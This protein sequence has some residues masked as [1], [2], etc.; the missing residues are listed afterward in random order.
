MTARS[1]RTT[2]RDGAGASS[3]AV[4]NTS[5]RGRRSKAL[6]N[7]TDVYATVADIAGVDLDEVIP[8][9]LF[10]DSVSVR[11]LL[12]DPDNAS[13]RKYAFADYFKPNGP[14]P[15]D[16]RRRAIRDDRWKLI[17]RQPRPPFRYEFYDLD[18]APPGLD[19]DDLCPCPENLDRD[20]RAA[21]ERL[22]RELEALGGP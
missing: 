1:Y 19:G 11:P 22:L 20:E 3:S 9:E 8:H 16:R 14:G 21:Y 6:V 12:E 10:L 2:C 13:I 15:Y 17:Q 7:T 18:N 4:L 5:S